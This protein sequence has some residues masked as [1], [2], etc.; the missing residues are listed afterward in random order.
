MLTGYAAFLDVLGFSSVVSG[1]RHAERIDAY[2]NSLNGILDNK[3]EVPVVEYVVFSDSIVI[4]TRDDTD[5]SFEALVARC[6]TVFGSLLQTEIAV[7]GAI[8]HGTFITSKTNS[9]TFVA[10][11]AII[12]AYDFEQKQDW[13]GIMLAPSVV[14]QIPDI[15][16][17]CKF[18]DPHDDEVMR[19]L[20]SRLPL[21]AYVQRCPSIPFHEA[22][23]YDGFAIVP[24]DG[25]FDPV[26]LR[27]GL[28]QSIESLHRLKSIA[29]NP[30]AQQKHQRAIQWL[31]GIHGNWR[32]VVFRRD[33]A[34]GQRQEA[35]RSR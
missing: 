33:Q 12:D 18:E 31:L 17:R 21:V 30:Q 26:S 3:R 11:R 29:P 22:A 27:D 1:D 34:D 35:A 6:S 24:S 5:Q 4:T 9:G 28:G 25:K 19:R 16:D 15:A 32:T 14:R 20:N 2:L 13:T 23:G 8:A 7:R 10:G